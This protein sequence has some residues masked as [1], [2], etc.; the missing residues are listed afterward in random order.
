[1]IFGHGQFKNEPRW[2]TISD[3]YSYVAGASGGVYSL[4]AA[5]LATVVINWSEDGT[6]KIRKVWSID[7]TDK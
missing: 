6:V 7:M 1:M 2:Q 5:H 3:P 4:I